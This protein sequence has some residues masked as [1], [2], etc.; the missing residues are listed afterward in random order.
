MLEYILAFISIHLTLLLP[1][2]IDIYSIVGTLD[3]YLLAGK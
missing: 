3:D 2:N 1:R